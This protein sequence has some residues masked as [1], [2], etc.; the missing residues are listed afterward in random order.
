MHVIYHRNCDDGFGAAWVFR[1]GYLRANGSEQGLV[2]YAANYGDRFPEIPHGSVVYIVDFSY[3][4][5]VLEEQAERL[6]LRVLDHHKTA[7]EDLKGLPFAEFDMDRSGAMMA[8]DFHYPD[9]RA[10]GLLQYVQDRDLWRKVL[11]ESEAITEYIR[12]WPKDFNEWDRM[13]YELD[14]SPGLFDK[15]VSEGSAILRRA[16]QQIAQA[17]ERSRLESW[18][19]EEVWV[20]NETQNFSEVAGELAERERAAFGAVYFDRAD[21]KRQW[22]LRSRA[23]F[24]VSEVAKKRGGGGHAQAAGFTEDR[25]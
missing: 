3:P 5:A 15:A 12:S 19:G 14:H 18:D 10:P 4:R 25:P 17:L 13:A 8:W 16:K 1:G 24:D 22:S 21:G 2:L 23:D 7:Q 6:R 11:P 20:A 9:E